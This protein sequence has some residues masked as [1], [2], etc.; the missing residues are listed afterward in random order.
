M[1]IVF[2]NCK[3]LE[4]VSGDI[5]KGC[6]NVE[7]FASSFANCQK[8]EVIPAGIFD[9]CPNVKYFEGVFQYTGIKEVPKDLFRYNTEVLRF[10][11]DG[12]WRGVFLGCSKLESVPE[13]LFKYNT[14][15]TH[16]EVCFYG[17]SNLSNIVNL[18]YNVNIKTTRKMF[19]GCNKMTGTAYPIWNNPNIT[20][21]TWCFNSCTKLSNY[22]DIPSN[23]K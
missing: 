16:F 2:N 12:D 19:F 23:W 1:S 5:F 20:S 10:G 6:T 7:N 9:D 21:Y 11:I 4:E 3:Q 8:L 14:K 18:E 13:D 15:A 17:C 22:S